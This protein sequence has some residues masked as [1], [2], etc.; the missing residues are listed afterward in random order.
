MITTG[1]ARQT[2][3]A[4]SEPY[5]PGEG[6][7]RTSITQDEGTSIYCILLT[8][9]GLMGRLLPPAVAAMLPI[10]ILPLGDIKSAEWLAPEYMGPRVLTASLLFT[11]AFLC[12]ETTVFFRLSLHALRRYALR[13]QPLFLYTHLPVF[14]LSLLLPSNLIVVFSTVF[15]DRFVTTVHNEIVGTAEQRGS[16]VRILSGSTS[17][18]YFEDGRRPRWGRISGAMSRKARSVSMVS[19]M[20][21]PSEVS[22]SSSLVKQYR[23]HPPVPLPIQATLAA[24]R[25]EPGLEASVVHP[26]AQSR[27]VATDACAEP[28]SANIAVAIRCH[29][30]TGRPEINSPGRTPLNASVATIANYRQ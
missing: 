10:V 27:R 11:I 2:V 7:K 1:A 6:V 3:P 24:P 4:T 29:R 23:M 9:L 26:Q 28:T 16:V 22:G 15:I 19:E 20:T 25:P 21:G 14:A 8:V 5:T 13:M 17:L 18:N 30:R 12:D